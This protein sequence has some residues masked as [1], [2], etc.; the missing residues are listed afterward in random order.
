MMDQSHSME[1]R[2]KIVAGSKRQRKFFEGL[3]RITGALHI[4]QHSSFLLI[5]Q[6]MLIHSIIQKNALQAY[7]FGNIVTV[8]RIFR[9]VYKQM[10]SVAILSRIDH[11]IWREYLKHPKACLNR[12]R[13]TEIVKF[14]NEMLDKHKN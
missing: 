14:Q 6:R 10:F 7:S 1:W 3:N 5:L 2:S 4:N 8:Q 12:A 9:I 11:P 13:R